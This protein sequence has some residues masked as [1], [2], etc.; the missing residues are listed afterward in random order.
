M[1]A[2]V[3]IGTYCF[4]AS[5]DLTCHLDNTELGISWMHGLEKKLQTSNQE[6]S[7]SASK[8]TGLVLEQCHS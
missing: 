8:N 6:V 5:S 7:P 1:V 4:L 2:A 3:S